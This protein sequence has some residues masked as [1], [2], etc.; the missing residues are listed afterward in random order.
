MKLIYLKIIIPIVYFLSVSYTA[1]ANSIVYYLQVPKYKIANSLYSELSVYDGRESGVNLGV[2][3]KGISKTKHIIASKTPISDQI[4]NM[5]DKSLERETAQAGKLVLH[6]LNFDLALLSN[7]LYDRGYFD[8]KAILYEKKGENLSFIAAIDK[9]ISINESDVYTRLFYKSNEIVADFITANV[10]K[11]SQG[12]GSIHLNDLINHDD[13]LKSHLPLYR[14][15]N[16]KDGVYESWESFKYQTPN[17]QLLHTREE[18][19]NFD[20]VYYLNAKGKKEKIKPKNVY[21][22]VHNKKAYIVTKSGNYPLSKMNNDFYFE[23][24]LF[25]YRN[26]GSVIKDVDHKKPY[27][28]KLDTVDGSFIKIPI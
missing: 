23:G 16:L 19:R 12:A 9:K 11:K 20:K 10:Y 22:Y 26:A 15:Q 3:K 25:Q 17:Y 6:L 7:A 14:D 2:V 21:A 8:F 27:R 1:E 24:K 13:Y 5:F 18:Q 28:L 4:E